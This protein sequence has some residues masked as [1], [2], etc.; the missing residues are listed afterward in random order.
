MVFSDS[1]HR[2]DV[3]TLCVGNWLRVKQTKTNQCNKKQS[4]G[5]QESPEKSIAALTSEGSRLLMLMS[6]REM[7][8]ASIRVYREERT[9]LRTCN[10]M[11]QYTVTKA[12]HSCL[13][14]CLPL[15]RII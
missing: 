15:E 7:V 9:L 12:M 10:E 2:V 14:L 8:S 11:S 1:C 4:A 3:S 6:V 5:E 13:N